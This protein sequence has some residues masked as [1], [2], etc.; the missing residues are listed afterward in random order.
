MCL[1]SI[2]FP[3]RFACRRIIKLSIQTKLNNGC[4]SSAYCC[5]GDK[6]VGRTQWGGNS[7]ISFSPKGVLTAKRIIVLLQDEKPVYSTKCLK[8]RRDVLIV[9]L[10]KFTF[11]LRLLYFSIAAA[12]VAGRSGCRSHSPFVA[13]AVVLSPQWK[14]L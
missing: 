8:L 3:T 6:K 14:H 7:I 9:K 10:E 12:A 11:L 13:E 5:G 1:I 2:N 4:N